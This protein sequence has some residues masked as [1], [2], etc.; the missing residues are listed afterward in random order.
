MFFHRHKQLLPMATCAL[1][2]GTQGIRT[3]I[4]KRFVKLAVLMIG[5]R[6]FTSA[7][8][9]K[10]R[11]LHCL[12][13]PST[14]FGFGA[15]LLITGYVCR[16]H[17]PDIQAATSLS[18]ANNLQNMAESNARINLAGVLAPANALVT[19]RGDALGLAWEVARDLFFYLT[20]PADGTGPC[21][22]LD[23][24]L[25]GL[26]PGFDQSSFGRL[27]SAAAGRKL[28]CSSR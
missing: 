14:Q 8:L 11:L 21:S 20:P 24:W 28:P 15:A 5:L 3:S 16:R 4:V 9:R 13:N 10:R 23:I 19:P 2:K 26:L 12:V 22:S 27:V 7:V 6:I 25:K 17:Q 1:V 18:L